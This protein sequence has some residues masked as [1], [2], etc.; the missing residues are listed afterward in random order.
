MKNL[1]KKFIF[2]L[3]SVCMMSSCFILASATELSKQDPLNKDI[4][5]EKCQQISDEKIQNENKNS[6]NSNRLIKYII[7]QILLSNK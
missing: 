4:T 3:F 5:F 1:S 2:F 7:L 6:E